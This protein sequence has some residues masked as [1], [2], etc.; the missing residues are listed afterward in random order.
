MSLIF[1]ALLPYENILTM[2]FSQITVHAAQHKF[3]TNLHD[4]INQY[5]CLQEVVGVAN[6]KECEMSHLQV[7]T[8]A[9]Q[10]KSGAPDI[11]FFFC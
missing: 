4:V 9:K 7:E 5:V 2:K 8:N 10:H 11:L 1:V 3:H 6:N